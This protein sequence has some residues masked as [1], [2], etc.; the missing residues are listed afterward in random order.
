MI[1]GP[2]MGK[3]HLVQFWLRLPLSSD[4]I[5]VNM[6]LCYD[7]F[8]AAVRAGASPDATLEQPAVRFG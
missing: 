8:V 5:S 7:A 3:D 4:G 1:R 6:I 2:R